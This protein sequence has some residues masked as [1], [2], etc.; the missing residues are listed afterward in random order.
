MSMLKTMKEYDLEDTENWWGVK[1]SGKKS[2]QT[3]MSWFK[4]KVQSPSARAEK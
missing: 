4:R 2:S 1:W 3:V